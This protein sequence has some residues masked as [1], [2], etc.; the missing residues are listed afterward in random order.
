MPCVAEY[1]RATHDSDGPQHRADGI[2]HPI[3]P[4]RLAEGDKQLVHF[5]GNSIQR[6][7]DN[8]KQEHTRGRQPAHAPAEGP[9][10]QRSETGILHR[11]QNLV[12]EDIEKRRQI[13]IRM[14]LSREIENQSGVEGHR[15][16]MDQCPQPG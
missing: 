1:G 10:A 9:V 6:R 15:P 3:L 2:S 14:R 7:C 11:M 16:P 12:A 8:G 4:A 13:F 5:I